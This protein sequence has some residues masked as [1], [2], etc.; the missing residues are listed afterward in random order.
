MAPLPP[1]PLS[2]REKGGYPQHPLPAREK[3][4]TPYTLSPL[5]RGGTP[6]PP[7]SLTHPNALTHPMK[8]S[9]KKVFERSEPGVSR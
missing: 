5:E 7:N 3:G 1:P 8:N 2:A 6:Y 9:F 4:G